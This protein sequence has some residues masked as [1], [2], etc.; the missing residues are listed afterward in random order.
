MTR[1]GAQI[2]AENAERLRAWLDRVGADLPRRPGGDVDMSAVADQ[3][4]L[5]SRQALYKNPE[6]RRLLDE[7]RASHR[8]AEDVD[9]PPR[10]TA[11]SGTVDDEKRALERRCAELEKRV[12]GLMAE[13]ADLRGRLKRREHVDNHLARTGR[14]AR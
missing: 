8:P 14:L 12:A 1:N 7:H 2:G 6:C 10:D 11:P 5:T 13:V 9:R 4:G 3:A